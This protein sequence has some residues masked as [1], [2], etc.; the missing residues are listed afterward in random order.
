MRQG[1][2]TARESRGWSQHRVAKVIGKDRTAVVKYETG[3][4]DI[5]GKVLLQL[6]A[7]YD[8]PIETILTNDTADPA[9]VGVEGD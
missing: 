3:Q 9:P 2:I 6:A 7:L 4:C 8:L 1:L 5:P